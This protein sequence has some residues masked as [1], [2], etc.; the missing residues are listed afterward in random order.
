[1]KLE[2]VASPTYICPSLPSGGLTLFIRMAWPAA[3]QAM[4]NGVAVL[5]QPVPVLILHDPECLAL[6]ADVFHAYAWRQVGSGDSCS[7]L[8]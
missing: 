6:P 3:L 2:S 4:L 8:Q 7:K 5:A 1:M